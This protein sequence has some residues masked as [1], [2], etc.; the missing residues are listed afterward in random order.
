M[1]GKPNMLNDPGEAPAVTA[2]PAVARAVEDWRDWLAHE[3]RASPHT[4]AA[5]GRDLA[6]FLSFLT[7][8]LGFPPGLQD[9]DGLTQ[10]DFRGFLAR[11]R[12]DG[13]S[14]AS[15]ARGLAALR[16]FF[17]F[18]ERAGLVRNTAIAGVRTPKVPRPVPKA[19][20]ADEAL[21][22]V[23]AAAEMS[24]VPW[25]AA[26][27]VAFFTLL[28]GCG[29][30]IGEAIALDRGQAPVG[31]AALVVTGK[32]DK[33][34]IVPV[35][36]IVAD[37]VDAYL[38]ACP[39]PLGDTGPLFVGARGKR[40][41][42]GVMQRQM[43]RLRARLGLPETASP[44]ALRHSFATHLLAGGGDL[45]TIQELLGHAS[46]SATQRYTEVDAARLMAVH[47]E[48]HPRSRE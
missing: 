12:T 18:L 30:R 32:G 11:R 21:E 28:Y 29:L 44:H 41:N 19:L 20:S 37:A 6:R 7:G 1:G 3:R 39:Y 24:P 16:G 23:D 4:R 17:R 48:A 46:L 15:M 35:L 38:E 27:D 13:L 22:A 9:L 47:N 2:E 34:R 40:L 43:R 10:A 42:P 14:R 36:S 45:R 26:R 33:Q 31:G 8:H 25:I 5:Y